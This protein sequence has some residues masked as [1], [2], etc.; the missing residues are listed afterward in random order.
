M[1]LA[2]LKTDSVSYLKPQ[3]AETLNYLKSLAGKHRATTDKAY[4][5]IPTEQ[6]VQSVGDHLRDL[7]YIVEVDIK[8]GAKDKKSTKHIAQFTLTNMALFDRRGE[9]GGNGRVLVIN[10][11][12]GECSLVVMA[13]AIRFCCAN[14]LIAG[15]HEFFQKII[16][17]QGDLVKQQLMQ[18]NDKV[19]IACEY[20]KDKFRGAVDRMAAVNL[21]Y[22]RE[23]EIVLALPIPNQ[24]KLMVIEMIHPSNRSK[25][26]V[27]DQPQNLWTLYNVVNECVRE[28]ARHDLSDFEYNSSLMN[29]IEELAKAA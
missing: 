19:S 16:H 17:R 11:Y 21:E 7:G 20:L 8:T 18:L 22:V 23:V 25:V 9:G 13:G 15:E 10:S 6:I 24:A 5:H 1:T 27:Q 12:N 14:G 3:D 26:R 29:Q 28:A 2:L 4:E